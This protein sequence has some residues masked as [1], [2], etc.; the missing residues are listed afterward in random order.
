MHLLQAQA[1]VVADGSEP[2]DLGQEPGDLLILSAADTE[3]VSL[4]AAAAAVHLPPSSR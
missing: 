1:G 4:S 2:V 3:L